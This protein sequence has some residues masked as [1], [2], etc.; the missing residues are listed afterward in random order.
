MPRTATVPW[1]HLEE[2]SASAFVTAG[3]LFLALAALSGLTLLDGVSHPAWLMGV[4]GTGGTVAAFVG[5]AGLYPGLREGSPTLARSGLAAVVVA[6]IGLFVFPLC[7]LGGKSGV[8][9]PAPP[10]VAFVAAMGAIVLAFL[11]FGLGSV[12]GDDHPPSVGLLMLALVGT[13]VVLLG[14]DLHYGGAPAW[15]DVAVN[16]IQ[17]P[18]LVG[19]GYLLPVRATPTGREHDQVGVTSG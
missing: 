12:R 8:P 13:F 11:L 4:M 3:V 10:I 5:L 15:V 18:L 19:I 7:L 1:S 9:I 14:A 17:A 6:G 2:W 16:A